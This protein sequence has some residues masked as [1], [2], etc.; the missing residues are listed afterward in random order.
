MVI[1]HCYVSSPEGN[2]NMTGISC[3]YHGNMKNDAK[4]SLC[5]IVNCNHLTGLCHHKQWFTYMSIHRK[6]TKGLKL[7]MSIIQPDPFPWSISPAESP[8]G[9]ALSQRLVNRGPNTMAQ[10]AKYV[11]FLPNSGKTKRGCKTPRHWS[12]LVFMKLL[13]S[14]PSPNFH[15]QLSCD[16]L[17]TIA[18][19]RWL[20]PLKRPEFSQFFKGHRMGYCLWLWIDSLPFWETFCTETHWQVSPNARLL[21][22]SF[23]IF[24]E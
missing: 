17:W 15:S 22:W 21:A 20:E 8:K 4:N 1:F 2:G 10:F 12:L 9:I 11:A 14:A 19:P 23:A 6:I 3:E 5:L 13:W 7:V 18:P 24:M 16:N